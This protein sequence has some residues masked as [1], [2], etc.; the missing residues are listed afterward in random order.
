MAEQMIIGSIFWLVFFFIIALICIAGEKRKIRR[1]NEYLRDLK[2][3]TIASYA[4]DA[5]N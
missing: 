4:V 5:V 1:N 3:P 2:N